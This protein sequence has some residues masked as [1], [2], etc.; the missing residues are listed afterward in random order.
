MR[1]ENFDLPV[2]IETDQ[3]GRYLTV[4][5]AAQAASLL[6]DKWPGERGPKYRSALK[7]MMDVMEQRKAVMAARKAFTAAAKEADIFVREGRQ[8]D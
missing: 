7:A 3:V 4:T 8:L 2:T 5:R 1:D 6:V